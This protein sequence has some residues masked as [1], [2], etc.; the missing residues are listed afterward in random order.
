M[1][2]FLIPLAVFEVLSN[3]D[4]KVDWLSVKPGMKYPVIVHIVVSGFGWAGNVL[5]WIVG[6]QYTTTFKASLVASSHPIL[7]VM[8]MQC[9]GMPVSALEWLG[10]FVSFGGMVL[11]SS[12]DIFAASGGS[13]TES[14]YEFLGLFLCLLAAAAEVVV[15]F[16]RIM[17]KKYV[18]LMQVRPVLMLLI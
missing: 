6:L 10:V 17:T 18:P 14:R 4:N 9:K 16:N 13:T 1:L 15:L 3:K 7:L 11:S 2:I 5:F 8:S 12:K